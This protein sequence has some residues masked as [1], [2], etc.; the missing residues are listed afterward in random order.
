[1]VMGYFDGNTVTAMW[2]YAQY[3]AM[4]Q[5]FHGTNFGP[6]TV[7]AVNVISGMTGNADLSHSIDDSSGDLEKD[8]SE[9]FDH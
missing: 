1:M 2:N 9:W 3:F 8:V 5:S 6:S 7:G 4:N